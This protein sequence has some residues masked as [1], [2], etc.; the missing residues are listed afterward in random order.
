MGV[1]EAA[2]DRFRRPVPTTETVS[3]GLKAG[4]P[5]IVAADD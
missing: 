5:D 2:A 4:V 3:A 1:G